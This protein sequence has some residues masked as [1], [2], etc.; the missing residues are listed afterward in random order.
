V[1]S[2]VILTS[3]ISNSKAY[4]QTT[5]SLVFS[6]PKNRSHH[7]SIFF[8]SEVYGYALGDYTI[9]HLKFDRI[10]MSATAERVINKTKIHPNW[11]EYLL[12]DKNVPDDPYLNA[13]NN[14]ALFLPNTEACTLFRVLS[15]KP[16]M[17]GKLFL[18]KKPTFSI[19]HGFSFYRWV[20]A[21]V[22]KRMDGLFMSGILNWWTDYAVK[23][24]PKAVGV[25]VEEGDGGSGEVVSSLHG[26]IVVVFLSLFGLVFSLISFAFELLTIKFWIKFRA[27]L[28]FIFVVVKQ[29]LVNKW[30]SLKTNRSNKN[31]DVTVRSVE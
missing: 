21:R 4:Y 11:K 12:K 9:A 29:I 6:M 8:P 27:V 26:N 2:R 7:H 25:N 17:K 18:S 14:S 28:I 30:E 20:N 16:K 23:H 31:V 22:L 10:N 5:Y 24:M 1:Y 3:G 19:R 13:C 15:K